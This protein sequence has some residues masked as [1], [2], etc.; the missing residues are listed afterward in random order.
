MVLKQQKK[1]YNTALLLNKDNVED[2]SDNR[3]N[4]TLGEVISDAEI[5]KFVKLEEQFFKNEKNL[6]T[7]QQLIDSGRYGDIRKL[8]KMIFLNH[9]HNNAFNGIIQINRH[10][11]Y[12]YPFACKQII[13]RITRITV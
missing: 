4:T 12:L 3:I 1:K 6:Q 9:R 8:L 10:A 11:I 2:I 5:P 7:K 13:F